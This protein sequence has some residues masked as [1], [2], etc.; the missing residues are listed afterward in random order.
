MDG[1]V[2]L[3]NKEERDNSLGD[4]KY[5]APNTLYSEELQENRAELDRCIDIY[6]NIAFSTFQVIS[7][8]PE[9]IRD[10]T[11]TQIENLIPPS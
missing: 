7:E 10:W 1:T 6:N 11:P 3:D 5:D 9:N 8:E 4:Q 2:L